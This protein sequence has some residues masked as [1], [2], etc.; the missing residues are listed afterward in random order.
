MEIFT[1]NNAMRS[2][3][4]GALTLTATLLSTQAQAAMK[5]AEQHALAKAAQNTVASLI[6]MPFV[7]Y[8][9][10]ER[11]YVVSAPV[12]TANWEAEKSSEE[13]AVPVGGRVGRVFAIAVPAK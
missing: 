11:W 10:S 9:F 6:S 8:N 3:F 12:I 2:A 7:N 5:E 13:C 4:A 1:S